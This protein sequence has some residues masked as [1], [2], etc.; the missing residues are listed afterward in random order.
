[1]DTLRTYLAREIYAATLFVFAAFLALFA[2]FDLIGE[3]TDLGKGGY[4]LQH[5]L[6]YVALTVPSHVYELFPLAVLIGTLYTLSHLASNSEYTVMRTSGLA[7]LRAMSTLLRIGVVFAVATLIFGE[8]IAP[9]SEKAAKQLKLSATSSIVASEF[10]TGLWVKDERRFVNVREVQPDTSLSDIRVFE[11]D[12]QYRLKSISFAKHGQYLGKNVWRL[13][14]IVNT[15]FTS[16]G[17]SVQRV[18]EM[19]WGSVLTPDILAVLFIVP[20][21][22]SAWN[23][24]QYSRHLTENRQKA[25]RYEIAMW[26]KLM[27]PFVSLVMMALALPFAYVHVRAGGLGMKVFAGIMLGVFFHFLNSLFSHL[28]LLQN[29]QPFLAAVLPSV[30]FLTAAMLMMWWAER[31]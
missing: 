17:S 29:W 3:L 21:R 1:M 19:D 13:R 26:K 15:V 10:H 12:D 7:P 18:A 22:M 30:L 31:R 16:G 2:F 27:Y 20:D 9:I 5:A 4:R 23:L 14:D 28:G 6:A 8:L 11:F 25:E 24:Y